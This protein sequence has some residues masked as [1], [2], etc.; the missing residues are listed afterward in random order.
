MIKWIIGS[1]MII[2]LMSGCGVRNDST[3]SNE[4]DM[5]G[6][7]FVNNKINKAWPD[8][9]ARQSDWNNQNPNFVGLSDTPP[10]MERDMDK[11]RQVVK[12]YTDY[13]PGGVWINGNTM[14]VTVY[15]NKD[16]SSKKEAK[17]A[18][19]KL[20]KII[21]QAFPRYNVDVKIKHK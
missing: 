3:Y 7:R 14:N 6:Q 21:L 10:S 17:R 18:K 11:A 1:I 8:E 5:N 9:E 19:D 2:S 15:T 16:F 13:T 20:H 12:E 4:N